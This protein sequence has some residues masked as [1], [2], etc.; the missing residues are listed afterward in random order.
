VTEVLIER[1]RDA[2]AAGGDPYRGGGVGVVFAICSVLEPAML[3][4]AGGAAVGFCTA[5]FARIGGGR[6]ET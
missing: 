6:S 4:I 3:A 2:I 5:L 1:A